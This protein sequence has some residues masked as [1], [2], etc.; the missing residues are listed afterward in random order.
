MDHSFGVGRPFTVGVEE[1]LLL[2]DAHTHRLAHVADRVLAKMDV[3][4]EAAGHEAYAAEIEL[5]SPPCASAGEAAASLAALRAR[6]AA[7]GAVLMGAGVHPTAELGDVQLVDAER[8]R[9]VGKLMRGLFRRTPECALHVHVGMPDSQVA[10]RAFNALRSYLPLLQ[11]L[12]ANSPFW[13]GRDS[14]L[15]SSRFSLV[16]SFPGR[17]VPDRFGD[18]D[19]YAELVTAVGRAGGLEDYTFVWWDVRLHPRLGTLELREMDAQGS[20]DSAAGLAALVQALAYRAA[21]PRAGSTESGIPTQVISESSFRASR[22]GLEARI[23]SND[24]ERP[25]HEVARET[26]ELARP[27]AREL[28]SEDA[29]E[30][31]E[32]ILRQGNGSDRQREAYANGGF[33]ATIELLLRETALAK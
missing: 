13:F 33:E 28:G 16:R 27:Y 6:A 18:F 1:E 23:V 31:I 15:A 20:L 29:L 10:I 24:S 5:R 30:Q 3:D 12:S 9:R 11:G 22:D 8:Y 4:G 2:V 25:L 17:G 7:A 21:E 32:R 26:V 14:G 19:Q